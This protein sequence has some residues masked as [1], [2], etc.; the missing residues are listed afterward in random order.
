VRWRKRRRPACA[1]ER[2][3]WRRKR[4]LSVQGRATTVKEEEEAGMHT[5]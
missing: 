5:W 2:W 4:R 1:V 3:Q